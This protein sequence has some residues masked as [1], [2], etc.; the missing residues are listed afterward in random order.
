MVDV[1]RVTLFQKD[2]IFCYLNGIFSI[3]KISNYYY[4]QMEKGE[5]IN[6]EKYKQQN[7]NC[8]A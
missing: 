5:R 7:I 8:I 1:F 3:G 2:Y 6:S 4:S